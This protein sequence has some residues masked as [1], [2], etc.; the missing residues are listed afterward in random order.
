MMLLKKTMYGKLVTK[1][2]A[3]GISRCVL[4]TQYKTDKSGIKKANW[5]CW[6]ENTWCPCTCWKTDYN[7]KIIGIEG[8]FPSITGLAITAVLDAI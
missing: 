3:V 8:K 5:W 4:K 7:T 1:V 2:N 6:Q